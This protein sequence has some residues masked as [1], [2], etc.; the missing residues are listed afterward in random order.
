MDVIRS[1]FGVHCVCLT[2]CVCVLLKGGVHGGHSGIH[3]CYLV[4]GD[5]AKLIHQ[6]RDNWSKESL[7]IH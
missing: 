6:S 5:A 2:E 1:L 4:I 3:L 7:S